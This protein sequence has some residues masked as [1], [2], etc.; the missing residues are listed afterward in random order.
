MIELSPEEVAL[1]GVL[2]DVKLSGVTDEVLGGVAETL[3]GVLL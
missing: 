2:E 1:V 3:V